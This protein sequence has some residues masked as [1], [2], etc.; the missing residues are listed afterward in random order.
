MNKKIIVI[1]LVLIIAI[2][3]FSPTT[4]FATDEMYSDIFIRSDGSVDPSTAP[5]KR[6]GDTYFLTEDIYNRS[7]VVEKDGVV[8]DGN[9]HII[10]GTNINLS[11]GIDITARKNVVLRNF[12]ISGFYFGILLDQSQNN[13]IMGNTILSCTYIMSVAGS[14]NNRIYHNNFLSPPNRVYGRAENIWD[15]DYPDGGNFW[16][17]SY[18]EDYY[19]GLYQNAEG[20]DGIGDI[21]YNIDEDNF[22]NYPLMGTF[23]IFNVEKQGVMQIIYI[24]SNSKI[25]SVTYDSINNAVSFYASDGAEDKHFCRV[26]VPHALLSE[27]YKVLVNGQDPLQ[28]N[29]T[30]HNNGTHHWIYFSYEPP[31]QIS[32]VPEITPTA[33]VMLL[34]VATLI[35]IGYKRKL[36]V[37]SR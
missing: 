3:C 19:C 14:K 8:I 29:Y 17:G 4:L 36:K 6:D 24:I 7:I 11:K 21:I 33:M 34:L 31:K 10:Q 20:S 13:V 35:S 30:L 32:I 15:G 26:C 5:I 12:R 23:S 1:S 22:D 37:K 25:S 16:S 18:N 2:T 27:P 28:A 9:W